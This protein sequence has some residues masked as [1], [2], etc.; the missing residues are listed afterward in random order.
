MFRCKGCGRVQRDSRALCWRC[1]HDPDKRAAFLRRP[2]GAKEPT[3]EELDALIA[4][5]RKCLPPW[6]DAETRRAGDDQ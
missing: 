5:Q 6:W 3:L 1:T 2:Q 4:E